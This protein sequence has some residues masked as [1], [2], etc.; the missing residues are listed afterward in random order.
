MLPLYQARGL[1][2]W[3]WRLLLRLGRDCHRHRQCAAAASTPFLRLRLLL[4]RLLRLLLPRTR[5]VQSGDSVERKRGREAAVSKLEARRAVL[6]H[7][8]RLPP[9]VLA[10]QREQR[11]EVALHA[12]ADGRT[13]QDAHR[14]R[15]GVAWAPRALEDA[16]AEER[17]EARLQGAV[18]AGGAQETRGEEEEAFGRL[19][20]P[21]AVEVGAVCEHA[22]DPVE[23]RGELVPASAGVEE[24]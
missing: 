24:A 12:Q 8:A 18:G 14:E 4:L 6:V 9:A 2:L 16:L 22:E 13:R 21:R 5:R 1:Y 3:T 15:E 19:V 17:G 23:R 20:V 11:R 10:L 7:P